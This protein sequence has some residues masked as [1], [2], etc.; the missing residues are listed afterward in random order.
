MLGGAP[1]RLDQKDAGDKRDA[2]E[3]SLEY[4]QVDGEPK[5]AKE[6]ALFGVCLP[7]AAQDDRFHRLFLVSTVALY[8]PEI[9]M[10]A[11]VA[12]RQRFTVIFAYVVKIPL[13]RHS[14]RS[15]PSSR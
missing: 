9:S 4:F 5:A 8:L 15:S 12:S 2:R 7:E 3:V 6:A 13:A 11:A 14:T 1:H 10:S